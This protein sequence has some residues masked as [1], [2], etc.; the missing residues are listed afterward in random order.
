MQK[1][2]QI[3]GGDLN[4]LIAPPFHMKLMRNAIQRTKYQSSIRFTFRLRWRD[5][6]CAWHATN[7][8]RWLRSA[9]RRLAACVDVRREMSWCIVNVWPAHRGLQL[10]ATTD[11]LHASWAGLQCVW[12]EKRCVWSNSM[13]L[14]ATTCP[15][16]HSSHVYPRSLPAPPLHF[17]GESCMCASD[18]LT[19]YESSAVRK[20]IK[21][22]TAA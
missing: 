15:A 8:R 13:P 2:S 21:K 4:P 7:E 1:K 9:A 10:H 17:T 6:E 12:G 14:S 5:C 18:R 22:I 11:G 16:S 3:L 20:L 19:L